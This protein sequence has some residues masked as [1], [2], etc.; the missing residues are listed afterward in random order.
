MSTGDFFA[1]THHF[2]RAAPGGVLQCG[3]QDLK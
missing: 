2:L 1:R 3:P